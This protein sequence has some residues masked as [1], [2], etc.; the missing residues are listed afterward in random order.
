MTAKVALDGAK[1]FGIVVYREEDRLWHIR[2]M[3]EGRIRLQIPQRVPTNGW[4]RPEA[5]LQFQDGYVQRSGN[6]DRRVERGGR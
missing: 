6:G 3:T 2:Q 4:I 5:T 1:D